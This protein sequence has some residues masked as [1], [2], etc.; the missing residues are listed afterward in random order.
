MARDLSHLRE[1]YERAGLRRAHLDPD[2]VVQF[3]R[4]WDEWLA[5]DPYDPAACVL[6]TAGADGRPSARV[7][8]CRGFDHDGFVVYTN[9]SSRKGRELDVNPW[10]SV[11]FTWLELSRQ[12]RIEGP[13]AKVADEVSDAYWASRPRGSRIG[14]WASAQSEEVADRA[15]LE[16]RRAEA[17][18]RFGVTDD[19]DPIERPPYWGGY[20]VGIDRI[21]FWQGQPDRLHD[22]FEYRR[23]GDGD[24][25]EIVRLS[26]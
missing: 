9:R 4:W 21:E 15:E 23:T 6:A 22:R 14:A 19:G 7:L 3:E 5:T 12:V 24:G 25:W 18:A 17:E 11:V 8:L 16:Q 20:V 13:V 26:P 2:P 1:S 10:A